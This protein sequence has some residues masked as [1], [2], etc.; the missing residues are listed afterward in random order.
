MYVVL[1]VPPE[2]LPETQEQHY[3]LQRKTKDN[4]AKP[5]PYKSQST[6]HQL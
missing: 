5:T 1:S 4:S 2:Y 6:T 3:Y